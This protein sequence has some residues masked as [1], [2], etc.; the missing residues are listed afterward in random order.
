MWTESEEEH[1][2]N[3]MILGHDAAADLFPASPRS[4]RT[5]NAK[6]TFSQ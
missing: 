3:V 4:A 5:W 6:A 1:R 2:D